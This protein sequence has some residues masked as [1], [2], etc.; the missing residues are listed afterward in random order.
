MGT[1]G[2][3]VTLSLSL[4]PTT[5]QKLHGIPLIIYKSREK[6]RKLDLTNENI[7]HL[8]VSKL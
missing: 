7:N 8:Y 4:M 5:A 3:C 6:S 1:V 2:M